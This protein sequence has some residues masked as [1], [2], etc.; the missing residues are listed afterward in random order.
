MKALIVVESPAKA[1]ALRQIVGTTATVVATAGHV[2]ELPR[3]PA[4]VPAAYREQAWSRL[5][6]NPDDDFRPLQVPT[7]Q[8]QRAL[9]RL[10]EL[11][12]THGQVIL[13][14]DDDREGAAIAHGVVEELKLSPDQVMRAP[15]R[16]LTRQGWQDALSQA[17]PLAA[18]AGLVQAQETRRAADRL[19]GYTFSPVAWKRVGPGT[20][21][22]RVQ[23]AAAGLVIRREL[24]RLGFTP[25]PLTEVEVDAT[26]AG[27]PIRLHAV[28]INGQPLAGPADHDPE[29]G[30]HLRGVRLDAGRAA[31]IRERL[32]QPNLGGATLSSATQRSVTVEIAP[33]GAFDTAGA[34]QA[35]CQ[36]T[37]LPPRLA[38]GVLQ[39]LYE[40][41]LITY[42]R[43]DSTT[44]SARGAA[45]LRQ[46]AGHAWGEHL[47]DAPAQTE[48]GV[49]E[50]IRPAGGMAQPG[51]VSGLDEHEASAYAL[52]YERALASQM[53]SATVQVTTT[54]ARLQLDGDTFDL[55]G[56]EERVIQAGHRS[57]TSP[58]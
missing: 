20:A 49:H 39:R 33:P 40:R 54:T 14:T 24:S 30:A 12:P 5:G 55:E 51:Q 45:A 18:D 56:R 35:I 16:E 28:A 41:G 36:A 31:Q 4:D 47:T 17:R 29:T 10:R 50:A 8:G 26:L 37:G 38:A 6:L 15:L 46:A 25:L 11:A 7:T 22:G 3:R 13:A 44:M 34:L 32:A 27:R 53:E 52:I 48:P 9:S 42:P 2:R 23:T 21:V 19:L 57:L 1:R 43:T 58:P